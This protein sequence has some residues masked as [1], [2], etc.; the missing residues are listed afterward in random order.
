MN[1]EYPIAYVCINK[2]DVIRKNSSS[3][4]VFYHLAKS[5]IDAQGIVFAATYDKEWNV[6]HASCQDMDAIHSFMGSKY[7]QSKLGDTLKA[8]KENLTNGRLVLFVGTPCQING[9][10]SFLGKEYENL[11]LVDI[12]CHG[13]PSPLVWRRYLEETTEGKEISGIN[14]RDKKDG[15][16][17]NSVKITYKDGSCYQVKKHDNRYFKGFIRDIYLRPSCYA[18]AFKGLNRKAD[19]TLADYWGIQEIHPDM[20]DDRGASLVLLHSAKG[21]AYWSKVKE[22]FHYQLT[23]LE[24]AVENNSAAVVSV[25][26]PKQRKVFFTE[27]EKKGVAAT[28]DKCTHISLVG[29]L[30]RKLARLLNPTKKKK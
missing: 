10:T 18:C 27:Y 25:A 22:S 13:V 19:I 3:G 1:T 17:E 14:F 20:F 12:I 16:K 28:V 8:V 2:D 29:R 4:G 23:D 6:V 30:K 15:W 7:V 21:E 11:L 24:F 9:L 5:V 26:L